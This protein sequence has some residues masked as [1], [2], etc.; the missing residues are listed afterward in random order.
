M[1]TQR[2]KTGAPPT[3]QSAPA[4]V[5][6]ATT[7]P[8]PELV[9][10][11]R[12]DADL[13]ASAGRFES[14][15]KGVSVSGLH[16]TL[17][18]NDARM[19]PVFA[20]TEEDLLAR[21]AKRR[22][23]ARAIT[24][25]QARF[26]R[27]TAPAER[28]PELREALARKRLVAAAYLKPPVELPAINAMVARAAAAPPATPDFTARQGYLDPAPEGI[29]ARWAWNQR[30][31][32]GQ[33]IRIVDVEGDWRFTHEDLA[34]NQ[35][36]VLGGNPGA[37]ATDITWR[38]HGTAVL[39]EYSGDGTG[40][41]IAG[42]ASDAIASAVSHGA[43]GTAAAITLAASRLS[44]GDILLLEMHRAGPRFGY[45][46]RDDQQGYIAIEWWP[47]DFGAILDATMRGIIVV[48]AAGNGAEDLDD[49]L[50]DTPDPH[51]PT[52]WANPFRRAGIDSGA[53]VVGAGAPPPGTHG[54]V[55]HGPDRSRLDFSNW[56]ALVDAQGWGRE[57]TTAGY[58]DLQ[59]GPDEDLWYTDT[60]GGTS[61][62]SPIVAGA[63]ACV[64][65]MLK[66][67][68][69]PVLDPAQVRACLRATGSPQQDAP[70]RPA[71]QRIGTRPDLRAMAAFAF[72]ALPVR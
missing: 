7:L 16:D 28:L 24:A 32:R 69:R 13:R 29:D 36:G 22:G 15:R 34:V 33:D 56:G 27:V 6:S 57:V 64:Q 14:A 5:P 66:A 41:G 47:D 9:V 67:R 63:I 70:A 19:T 11:M 26:Y 2:R 23:R 72:G 60:F 48:E 46:A 44:A 51:F 10:M 31:G 38:N 8:P 12:P 40:Y 4:A 50:Y 3:R 52:G 20:A 53:I 37:Y 17:V 61:S 25:E 43:L 62:A 71:T 39:G 45:A 68:G 49:V 30:G 35:G 21:M 65:G 59:G 55:H 54:A 1:A 58:G 18:R 42:I